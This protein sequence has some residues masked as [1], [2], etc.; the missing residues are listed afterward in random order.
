VGGG[1]KRKSPIV[2]HFFKTSSS[3]AEHVYYTVNLSDA[4]VESANGKLTFSFGSASTSGHPPHPSFVVK[5]GK[6][7]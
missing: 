7:A 3:G 1:P 4:L 6:P 5:L 2:L